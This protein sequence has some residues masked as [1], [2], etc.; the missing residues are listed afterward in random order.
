MPLYYGTVVLV[1]GLLVGL[2]TGEAR[3]VIFLMAFISIIIV[4]SLRPVIWKTILPTLF[5]LS[6]IFVGASFY[7]RYYVAHHAPDP[8]LEA[9][10]GDK[11]ELRG[12]I[13]DE[14]TPKEKSVETIVT[15]IYGKVLLFANS[16]PHLQYGDEISFKAKLK[17]PE[18]FSTDSGAMFDYPGFLS[19]DD[20]FFMESYPVITKLS[21]G[22][23]SFIKR[24]LFALKY[25]IVKGIE[26]VVPY[27]ESALLEGITVA[28]KRSLS[29]TM[30]DEFKT[31]GVSHIVVLSGYNVT[32]VALVIIKILARFPRTLAFGA[33]TLGIAAFCV[34]AGGTTTI[35]RAGIMS[36]LFLL[37][38]FA[39]RKADP[40]R[41]LTIAGCLMVILNPRILLYDTSFH[42]SFLATF[43]LINVAPF[44][45][46]M[47]GT[48]PQ[49]SA[50]REIIAS[51]LGVELFLIPYLCYSMGAISIVALPANILLL[52]FIPATM[53]SGFFGSVLGLMKIYLGIIP[54]L[55]AFVLLRY[56]LGVVHLLSKI[57]HA[58]LNTNMPFS[59]ALWFYICCFALFLI[60]QIF[61]ER[62]ANSDSQKMLRHISLSLPEDNRA[63]MS[64][65]TYRVPE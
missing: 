10:V 41:L 38:R 65:P 11:I 37:S 39:R 1:A 47:L 42:L 3:M 36:F 8:R 55:V 5:I 9:Q 7:A 54:A 53:L 21:S 62:Q 29:A 50:I 17:V 60:R 57:P 28:G 22:N 27:P 64:A 20:I 59:M 19:K 31:A 58:L 56:E 30:N 46:Q 51:S 45:D 32:I 12:L 4:V 48:I 44:V 16:Y 63:Y 43:G 18:K 14:P 23:G 40:N 49:S 25:L 26:E 6:V 2:K 24:K 52:A 33:G 34:L 13:L 61:L 15:T 35:I